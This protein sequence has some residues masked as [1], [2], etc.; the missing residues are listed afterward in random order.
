MKNLSAVKIQ[1]KTDAQTVNLKY[2]NWFKRMSVP[3]ILA[4][5]HLWYF[6]TAKML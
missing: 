4:Q 5:G 3:K 6:K 1:H 2:Q